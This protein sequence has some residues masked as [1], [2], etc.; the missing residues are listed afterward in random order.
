[1]TCHTGAK[2]HRCHVC[3]KKC[4][5]KGDL[6][7][8]MRLHT[9]EKPQCVQQALHPQRPPQEARERMHTCGVCGQGFLKSIDLKHH[10]ATHALIS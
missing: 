1:M 2:P 10:L 4:G 5:R 7:I 8:H 3:G 9:G 6:K